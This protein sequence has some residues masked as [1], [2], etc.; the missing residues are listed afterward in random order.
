MRTSW[1]FNCKIK[2][3]STASLHPWIPRIVRKYQKYEQKEA[4]D[5]Y[6]VFFDFETI[7]NED[8]HKPYLVRYETEDNEQMEFMGATCAILFNF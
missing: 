6:K 5:Y 8:T 3:Q 2:S 7:T 1:V 4:T